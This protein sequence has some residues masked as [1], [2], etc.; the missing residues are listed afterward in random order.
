MKKQTK[1]KGTD[2]LKF[3]F[4][5]SDLTEEEIRNLSREGWIELYKYQRERDKKIA[6]MSPLEM[7]KFMMK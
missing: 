3:R 6:K 7:L 2:D 5:N 1:N 4:V